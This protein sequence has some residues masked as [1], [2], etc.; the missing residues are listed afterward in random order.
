MYTN[1]KNVKR[2]KGFK[3]FIKRIL[4]INNYDREGEYLIY[5]SIELYHAGGKFNQFRAIHLYN[6]IRKNYGCNI[7]PGID[8]GDGAYIAHA[9]DIVIGKT[10]VIGNNCRIY[11][12][13]DITAAVKNDKQRNLMHERRH[14]KIGDDCLLGNR[15]TI[16]GSIT[17]GNDVTIGACAVVTKDVPSHTVVKGINGFRPKRIEE[18]PEKYIVEGQILE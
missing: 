17:I 15:S 2:E 3:G 16:V 1:S 7:W 10:T 11:P 9:Q 8:L 4:K 5:K 6:K 13:V 18:I 14:A 12:H